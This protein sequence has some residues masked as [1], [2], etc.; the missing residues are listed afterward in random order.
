MKLKQKEGAKQHETGGRPAFLF[1]GLSSGCSQGERVEKDEEITFATD[2]Q[3][4]AYFLDEHAESDVE[5]ML[6]TSG[7]K[8]WIVRAGNHTYSIFGL[9]ERKEEYA[10]VR[11]SAQLSLHNTNRRR[12][13]S[14]LSTWNGLH[15][16]V[17]EERKKE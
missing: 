12:N 7:E 1:F 16:F 15:G 13:G 17:R 9:K 11:V 4:E 6:T 3:A 14:L 2:A 10:I 8:V 5:V